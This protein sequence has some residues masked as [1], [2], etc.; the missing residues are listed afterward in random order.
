MAG[1]VIAV[2]DSVF[3]SLDLAKAALARLNPTFRM[4]KST[5]ADDILAVA[6]D[7]DAI[8]VTY[9]KLT[10]DI[11]LPAHQVQGDRPLRPGRRQYRPAHRQGERHRRQLRAGLL[12]PR[13]FRSRHGA[14]AGADPQDPALQ[15]IGAERP[16]GNAGGGADPPYR[17]HRARPRRLRPYPASGRAQG[18][19][20]RHQGRS[21]TTPSSKP[22][23]FKAATSRASI[24]TP[25]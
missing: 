2:T 4:S 8:L 23:L 5:N 1:P 20:L 22:D 16:L 7:A 17:R 14:A 18:A 10:R 11:L 21:P 25:C 24:S 15:Q 12:H 9:A 3:P 19:G 6:K 13:S